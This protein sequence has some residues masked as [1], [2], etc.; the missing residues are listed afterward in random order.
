MTDSICFAYLY[1]F[2]DLIR[3]ITRY[4]IDVCN[5]LGKNVSIICPYRRGGFIGKFL[6]Q[7]VNVFS[8]PHYKYKRITTIPGF[9]WFFLTKEFQEVYISLGFG[10]AYAAVMAKRLK[11]DFRYNVLLHVPYEKDY[12]L[13]SKLYKKGMDIGL[14]DKANRIIAVSNYVCNSVKDLLGEQ[15]LFVS[16][17]GVDLERF[18]FS[19]D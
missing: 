2:K 4:T 5:E 14:F 15:K 12:H 19:K 7:K 10:E 18:F 8:L 16:Y 9:L 17:N 13:F 1:L 3:G 11:K 6:N